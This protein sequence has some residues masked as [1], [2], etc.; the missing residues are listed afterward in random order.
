[1][2]NFHQTNSKISI[3]LV[4]VIFSQL[5][6]FK[7]CSDFIF[8]QRFLPAEH[9]AYLAQASSLCLSMLTSLDFN[10]VKVQKLF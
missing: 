7:S 4:S 9:K 1:M 10:L 2:L 3:P 8:D 6:S 5:E